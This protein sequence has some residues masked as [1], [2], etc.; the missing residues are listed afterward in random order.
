MVKTDQVIVQAI[1]R[2]PQCRGV[3]KFVVDWRSY[4]IYSK[5]QACG[6]VIPTGA[7]RIMA[8]SNDRDHPL[9]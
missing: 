5:C 7:Y 4:R 6:E 3:N 2:C 1:C 9:F 8:I